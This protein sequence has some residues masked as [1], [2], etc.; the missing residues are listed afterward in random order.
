MSAKSIIIRT[1][2]KELYKLLIQKLATIK[3]I[4]FFSKKINN[5]YLCVIKCN[6]YYSYF[7]FPVT[8][9]F[10][11]NYIFIYSTLSIIL[12]ELL[13][14]YYE[15]RIAKRFINSQYFYYPKNVLTQLT[16]LSSLVLS[17]YSTDYSTSELYLI[18]KEVLLH[19][20]LANFQKKNYITLEGF[21]N[22]SAT[23]YHEMLEY[24]LSTSIELILSNQ[25]LFH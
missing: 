4:N 7:N 5:M 2:S 21:I 18:R 15:Q 24:I 14:E 6:N 12:S 1:H 20:L 19:E 23:N 13:I 9:S 25:N 10:Y 11:G 8:H 17:E 3:N 22:F 16:N